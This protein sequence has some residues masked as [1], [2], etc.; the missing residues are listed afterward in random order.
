MS[1]LGGWAAMVPAGEWGFLL[2]FVARKIH[3]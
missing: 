3:G 2:G 1:L